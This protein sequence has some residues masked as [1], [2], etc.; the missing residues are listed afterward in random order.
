MAEESAASAEDVQQ[1]QETSTTE[2]TV[3]PESKEAEAGAA[4]PDDNDR[5]VTHK[6]LKRV[7]RS[8]DHWKERALRLEGQLS[9]REKERET[10]VRK[11]EPRAPKREEF[12]DYE[13]Y[14][15]AHATFTAEQKAA[16]IV[17][18]RLKARDERESKAKA[19]EADKQLTQDWEASK[20]KAR[21]KYADYDEVTQAEEF[22]PTPAM[23]R[24]MLESDLKAEIAYY[25]A[26]NPEE[27]E[28]ISKLSP[29]RQAAEVIKLEDKISAKPPAKKPSKAPAP[30]DPVGGKSGGDTR[31]RDDLPIDEWVKQR[32]KQL[33][34]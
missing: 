1:Q 2:G 34:G 8:K 26:S 11:E 27:Q 6:D 12:E 29:L 31:L 28:R 17:E 24:A 15:E 18:E 20:A 7:L 4:K 5:P 32:N 16:H 10:P 30:I 3:E 33:Y 22:N 13:S 25:L 19:E 23:A 21:Q 9:V 14:L